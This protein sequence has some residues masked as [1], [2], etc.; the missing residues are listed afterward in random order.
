MKTFF[1]LFALFANSAYGALQVT[2]KVPTISA[3]THNFVTSIGQTSATQAQPACADLSNS[4]A[5]CSTDATNATNIGSGTLAA[6]RGGAG[7][8]SG[9]LKGNG[10]GTVS[11][12]ACADLSN[13]A[14]SC[15]TDTTV[16]SNISSGT[17]RAGQ[18]GVDSYGLINIGLKSSVASNAWTI[19]FKQADGSTDP[20]AGTGASAIGFRSSTAT[21]GSV[22]ARSVTAALSVVVPTSAT[23]GMANTSVYQVFIYAIDNSGTV[24]IGVARVLLDEGSLQ[25]T[26][27]IT[28][29]ATSAN[30]LYGNNTLSGVAVRLIGRAVIT[31]STAGTYASNATELSVAPFQKPT[32][33]YW[34]GTFSNGFNWTRSNASQGDFTVTGAGSF[35]ETQNSGFGTV[36]IAAT[37][38]PGI[39]FTPK[40]VGPY[41]VCFMGIVSDSLAGAAANNF[42]LTDGTTT[43]KT[44]FVQTTAA[45]LFVPITMCG[46]YAALN[47]SSTTIKVQGSNN[48]SNTTTLGNGGPNALEV[49]IFKM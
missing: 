42:Y 9:A 44:S 35:T 5:S 2:S 38:L 27:A 19:A 34:T 6:A 21:T 43:I 13:G 25:N 37:N 1:F 32:I 31:E 33:Q 30:V 15:S 4:A 41:W 22:T 39:T 40:Q 3:V 7:T 26:T 49:S 46:I 10:S 18:H 45:T 20:A 28:S 23:L 47:T 17:L 29:G 14:A 16:A 11:Q 8:I 24:D 12:A 48:G 36:T